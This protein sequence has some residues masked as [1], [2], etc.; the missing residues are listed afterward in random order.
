VGTYFGTDVK[1]QVPTSRSISWI[2]SKRACKSFTVLLFVH[3]Y[4]YAAYFG[5]IESKADECTFSYTTSNSSSAILLHY[6][7]YASQDKL[8][9]NKEA[10]GRK[11]FCSK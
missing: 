1:N 9:V 10:I 8:L 5:P 2:L 6:N 11:I 3:K 7:K 4:Y